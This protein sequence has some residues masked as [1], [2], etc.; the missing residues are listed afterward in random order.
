[1]KIEVIRTYFNQNFTKGV[2]L[3]DNKF[4][5][6]T[7]EPQRKGSNETSCLNRCINAGKYVAEYEYSAKFK[8]H[9]IELKNVRN[10][11]EIKIHSG[12]FRSDTRGC[13]L[14]GLRSNVGCVLDSRLAVDM[15]N[16]MAKNAKNSNVKIEVEVKEYLPSDDGMDDDIF[17][18]SRK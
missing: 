1:M 2:M 8:K 13:I 5:G 12:N 7:L 9:L 15:L 16:N 11:T 17:R 14:V 4:F 6:Y 18:N 10:R 3:V